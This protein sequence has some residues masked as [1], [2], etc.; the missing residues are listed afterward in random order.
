MYLG[1]KMAEDNKEELIEI[2]RRLYTPEVK[3][4][5]FG[6][7]AARIFGIEIAAARQ[8]VEDDLLYKLRDDRRPQTA[9]PAPS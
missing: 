6:R 5:I 8:G 4:K 3:D 7:N 9:A 2:T 1:C